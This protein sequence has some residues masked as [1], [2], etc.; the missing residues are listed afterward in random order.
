MDI[1][2]KA[3]RGRPF[4]IDNEP[5]SPFQVTGGVINLEDFRAIRNAADNLAKHFRIRGSDLRL[6]FHMAISEV[7]KQFQSR[8]VRAALPDA[9][10]R[11]YRPRENIIEYL[12]SDEGFGPWVRAEA[13]TRPLLRE[14]APRAYMGLANFL[15]HND[16]PDGLRIPTLK[17]VNDQLLAQ[18]VF[19]EDEAH[20]VASARQRRQ[21]S[22]SPSLASD[23]H[24]AAPAC[25]QGARGRQ[26]RLG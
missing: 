6:E 16:L 22:A 3:I 25:E 17:E 26:V 7:V 9:P 15:R 10:V 2:V 21:R 19:S 11:D 20:K 23:Q 14:L 24:P 8:Q 5:A 13:L 4:N 18:G 12:R 1:K